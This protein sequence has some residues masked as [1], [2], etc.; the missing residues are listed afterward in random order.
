MF[1]IAETASRKDERKTFKETLGMPKKHA[2]EVDGLL[3]YKFDR[4]ARNLSD[5]MK[6][7]ELED[8]YGLRFISTSQP[9][10]DSPTG[11][12]VCRMLANMAAFFT[13]QQSLDVKDGMKKRVENWIVRHQGSV[14]LSKHRER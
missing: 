2:H 11:R 9:V 10:D 1:R 4:A 12:M 14:W 13:E 8:K 7:E 3:F 5:Y 6:L